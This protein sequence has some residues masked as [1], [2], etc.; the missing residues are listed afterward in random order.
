MLGAKLG[1]LAQAYEV[2]WPIESMNV[3]AARLSDR[4][5]AAKVEQMEKAAKQLQH[6]AEKAAKA[7]KSIDKATRESL[8]DS[9]QRI[10]PMAKEVRERVKDE[11][12]AA[13][14]V[15][16]LLTQTTK[17]REQLTRLSLPYADGPGWRGVESGAAA[18]ARAYGLPKP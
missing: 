4:E 18:V 5:L 12:P 14:E 15:G 17:V 13:V 2:A 11:R 9:I 1:A 16:Q 7:N 8:K 3:Q 10:E 6:E